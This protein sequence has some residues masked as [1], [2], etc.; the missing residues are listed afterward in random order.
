[1]DT[2]VRL[3]TVGVILEFNGI[4]L[5]GYIPHVRWILRISRPSR[6]ARGDRLRIEVNG[7][8]R[9]RRRGDAETRRRGDAETRRRGDANPRAESMRCVSSR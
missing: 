7:R 6:V 8:F 1:M 3:E 9:A 2:S 4:I 5:W